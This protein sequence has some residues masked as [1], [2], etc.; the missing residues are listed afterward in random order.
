MPWFSE[1]QKD[2][3][4]GLLLLLFLTLLLDSETYNS[5]LFVSRKTK[6]LETVTRGN[7][8]SV[9]FIRTAERIVFGVRL[10]DKE[11]DSTAG[12]KEQPLRPAQCST[13]LLNLA[14]CC[15]PVTSAFRKHRPEDIASS[16]ATLPGP[17][18]ELQSSQDYVV[19]PYLK[20]VKGWELET[21]WSMGLTGQPVFYPTLISRPLNN[22]I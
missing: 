15:T 21:S 2:V 19:R 17:H 20:R 16:R 9:F 8:W 7:H 1:L 14:S 11:T 10:S 4:W 12:Y 13:I 22:F 18:G 6:W 5:G 3:Y